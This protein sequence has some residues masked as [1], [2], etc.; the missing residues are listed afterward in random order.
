[1]A[2]DKGCTLSDLKVE[3]LKTI[4]P[5]FEKDVEQVRVGIMCAIL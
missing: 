2:E 5:L 1:M 3:D 4:N